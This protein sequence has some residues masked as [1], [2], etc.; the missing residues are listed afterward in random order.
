M[1]LSLPI[2]AAAIKL[3]TNVNILT[4]TERLIGDLPYGTDNTEGGGVELL[5]FI[6]NRERARRASSS[7]GGIL[8]Q[9]DERPAHRIFQIGIVEAEAHSRKRAAT[10]SR[11]VAR[12]SVGS[13]LAAA[14]TVVSWWS[15]RASIAGRS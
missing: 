6:K 7:G 1:D 14:M 5:R 12:F 13:L 15:L 10:R 4:L 11:K 8:N 3:K 2:T 9:S